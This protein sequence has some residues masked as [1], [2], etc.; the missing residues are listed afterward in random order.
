MI[1]QS[2]IIPMATAKKKFREKCHSRS[3]AKKR[4]CKYTAPKRLKDTEVSYS[5]CR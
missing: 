4:L 5:Y 2:P 1:P 3:G